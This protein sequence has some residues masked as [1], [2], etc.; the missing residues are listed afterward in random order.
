M[1]RPTKS[2]AEKRGRVT[3]VRLSPAEHDALLSR[4]IASGLSLSEYLRL[5]GLH[6]PLPSPAL[7]LAA[8]N[9]SFELVEQLRRMGVNLN[10]L[11]RLSHVDDVH[12][13]RLAA[14]LDDVRRLL[15]VHLPPANDADDTER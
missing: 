1:A 5:S 13:A 3:G 7:P 14:T 6:R 10:Q 8:A 15:A 2:N 11:T 4:A 12:H 9:T